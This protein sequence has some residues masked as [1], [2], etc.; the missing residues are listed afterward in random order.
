MFPLAI[1][2]TVLCAVTL[3]IRFRLVEKKPLE[4]LFNFL[5]IYILFHTLHITVISLFLESNPYLDALAPY[6]LIY[7]P[8]LFF[9]VE[10]IYNKNAQQVKSNML[11]HFIPIFVFSF[12]YLLM[13]LSRDLRLI[14]GRY[15]F[16]FLLF[17]ESINYLFYAVWSSVIMYKNQEGNLQMKIVLEMMVVLSVMAG[18]FSFFKFF[19][20]YPEN[21]LVVTSSAITLTFLLV[22]IGLLFIVTVENLSLKKE[23]NK[24]S[25]KRTY[26]RSSTISR[27]YG[28]NTVNYKL[29]RPNENTLT[30]F[31]AISLAQGE[32]EILLQRLSLLNTHHWYLNP[33]ADLPTLA[34]ELKTSTHQL[35]KTIN[36]KFEMN[37]NQYLNSLR[38]D[39]VIQTINTYLIQ[40]RILPSIEELYMSA[41]FN[42]K[43]TFN[44]H[45]KR[46]AGTT[47]SE[48]IQSIDSL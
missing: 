22:L 44:R 5:I 16:D 42:S 40:D 23:T 29:D 9:V 27:S 43:S 4:R 7:P 11:L 35:S 28:E 3:Y 19:E 8:L 12:L 26:K 48:Y 21:D 36:A 6:R 39:Y 10:L 25:K 47:P 18:T 14:Y 34:Q 37:F 31:S 32:D 2:I 15:V 1:L 30:P 33:D 45:F 13:S 20:L 46:I 41:G 38:V 17:T 24:N